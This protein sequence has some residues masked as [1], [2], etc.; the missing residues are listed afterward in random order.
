VENRGVCDILI[1]IVDGL[2]DIFDGVKAG[3]EMHRRAGVKMAHPRN[4]RANPHVNPPPA[5]K[6]RGRPPSK[7]K[8]D[9]LYG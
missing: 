1:A 2:K 4:L 8:A 5:P 3:L 9:Q 6:R 7:G